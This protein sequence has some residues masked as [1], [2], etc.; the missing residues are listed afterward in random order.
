MMKLFVIPPCPQLAP[1]VDSVMV[2]QGTILPWLLVAVSS[3]NVHQ[4]VDVFYSMVR[5]N[6]TEWAL[7]LGFPKVSLH[8][9]KANIGIIDLKPVHLRWICV[10]APFVQNLACL[11]QRNT[12]P[13][14]WGLKVKIPVSLS[15]CAYE[16]Q[17]THHKLHV[18]LCKLE[19]VVTRRLHDLI[20]SQKPL[21]KP[22]GFHREV[23]VV[24]LCFVPRSHYRPSWQMMFIAK[25][26]SITFV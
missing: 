2:P 21:L 10:M 7:L 20:N 15:W 26:A 16:Q 14:P 22:L 8:E 23:K 17:D 9:F 5:T 11:E 3:P 25:D 24:E 12:V 19:L 6:C 18:V 13:K 1:L 4:L